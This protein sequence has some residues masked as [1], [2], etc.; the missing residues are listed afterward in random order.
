MLGDEH[1]AVAAF[2][3]GDRL[4]ADMLRRNLETIRDST[5]DRE[6]RRLV[7]ET[8]RNRRT[9]RELVREPAF[10]AELDRG[11]DTFATFWE[12]QTPE[13]RARLVREG[14]LEAAERRADLGLPP[15]VEPEPEVG[16]SPLLRED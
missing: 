8:L 4:R 12:E 7:D 15:A 2:T 1:D 3:R 6:V 5:Q 13:E 16:D 11:M 9:V 14:Q 10:E